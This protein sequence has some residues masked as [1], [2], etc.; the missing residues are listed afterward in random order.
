MS[1]IVMMM[2][3]E[4]TKTSNNIHRKNSRERER[5]REREIYKVE[6]Q[7]LWEE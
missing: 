4:S 2:P 6:Q 5:E 3:F 1:T 7:L